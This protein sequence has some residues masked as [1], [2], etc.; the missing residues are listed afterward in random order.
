M[1]V[2]DPL[3]VDDERVEMASGAE[4]Q[5]H[6]PVRALGDSFLL[7]RRLRVPA[8]EI[9]HQR[10]S[11]RLADKNPACRC[12]L[13]AE[14]SRAFVYAFK[15]YRR[16]TLSTGASISC[17]TSGNHPRAERRLAP[18]ANQTCEVVPSRPD[19]FLVVHHGAVPCVCASSS[20]AR[21]PRLATPPGCAR[22]NHD[23]VVV[24]SDGVL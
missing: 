16:R 18:V 10:D 6:R 21:F 4:R 17:V 11:R 3:R 13:D 8:V 14:A 22:Q 2:G 9:T 15:T 20:F 1:L 7:W 19:R 5:R 24:S 23:P 12:V